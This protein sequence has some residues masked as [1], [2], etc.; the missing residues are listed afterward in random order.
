[1]D[2]PAMPEG[3]KQGAIPWNRIIEES[4][5]MTILCLCIGLILL[6]TALLSI[7][8]HCVKGEPV[9]V[10]AEAGNNEKDDKLLSVYVV[11]AVK[12]PGVYE[13]RRE[14][15]TMMP[16]RQQAMSSLCKWKVSIW[17]RPVETA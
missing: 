15:I 13:L 6:G 10:T 2:V 14:A 12:E 5:R 9:V 4:R 17:Q 16:S 1:M 7:L 11:G 3:L 8:F